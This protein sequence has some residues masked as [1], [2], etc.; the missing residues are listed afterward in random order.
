MS[1]IKFDPKQVERIEAFLE[2]APD[3]EGLNLQELEAWRLRTQQMI[4]ALD[5][6]EPRSERNENYDHWAELHEDLE[7]LLDEILDR[8]EMRDTGYEI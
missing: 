4:S 5:A 2:E 3:V 1:V 7:D 6:L 8:L